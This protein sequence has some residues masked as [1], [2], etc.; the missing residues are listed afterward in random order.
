MLEAGNNWE[1]FGFDVRRIGKH[2]SSA[3]KEFLWG[4]DSPVKARLDEMV[5]VRSQQGLT[6]YHGGTPV[7]YGGEAKCEAVMLPDASVLT[8]SLSMPRAVEADLDAV[9]ALEIGAH[10]PFP[11]GDTSYGWRVVGRSESS[12]QIQLAVVSISAT[13]SILGRDYDCH[14][15]G[16]YEVWAGTDAAPIVLNGFGEGKRHA[17]YRR[18]LIRVGAMLAYAAIIVVMVFGAAA[19]AKYVELQRVQQMAVE[20][21]REA[22]DASASRSLLAL[23]SESIAAVG[24]YVVEHPS[25][26]RELARLTRL[27]PDDASVQ[28]FTMN[29]RDIRLRGQAR[30]AAEV[31]E[32]LTAEPAYEEVTAPQAIKRLGN[33]GMEGFVLKIRLAEIAP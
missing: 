5:Q 33:T 28:Q 14:D 22:G 19:A 8:K 3:W 18:R 23:A 16:A 2:W 17:R 1:L 10:S 27:L 29:G 13:M 26:H 24:K 7:S 4:Y 6:H 20:V 11:A 15:P 9:M 25:P 32:Q 21:Q 12:L 31:M 30:N